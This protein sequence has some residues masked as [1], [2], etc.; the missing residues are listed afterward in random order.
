MFGSNKIVS[1]L[2]EMLTD[3]I[4]GRFSE[5]SYD[6]TELSRLEGKFRQYLTGK[7]TAAEKIQAERA[8]IKELVTD[9]SHQTKTPIA[10]I[11]LYTQ[12]LAEISPPELMPYVEQIRLQS[13]KL[14]FL[15]QS[16]TKISRLE[17][18]MIVLHPKPQEVS[19]LLEAAVREVKGQADAKQTT[20]LVKMEEG[21]VANYDMR[22]TT[23]A[24]GNLLD[25]AVKYSP[26]K[27][28]VTVCV[29][30]MEMF[31]CIRVEDEGPGIPEEEMAQV[32]ERFYR[33]KNAARADGN[34]VGL[35]LVRMIVCKERGY[36]KVSARAGSGSCF[37]MY[38]PRY[39]QRR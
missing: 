20:V 6:E 9:I 4:N 35:Y 30:I 27:S 34:G 7:E 18:D 5:T 28:T 24:L 19:L 15:I 21:A 16:L 37:R 32:F 10:N 38:L 12:L 1:R 39:I 36:M 14:E 23:E 26:E 17:S 13:E 25:N 33:G 22:W 31:I 8:A 3:A 2:D 29:D 11:S